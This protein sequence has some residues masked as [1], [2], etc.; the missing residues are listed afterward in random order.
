L[1]PKKYPSDLKAA[2]EVAIEGGWLNGQWRAS[3]FRRLRH[4]DDFNR[5]R[6]GSYFRAG[7]PG[8]IHSLG[9]PLTDSQ[10]EELDA[11]PPRW[12]CVVDSAFDLHGQRTYRQT[13][14]KDP[15]QGAA[16]TLSTGSIRSL[17][18]LPWPVLVVSRE[19]TVWSSQIRTHG[20]T[21]PDHV[22]GAET[23]VIVSAQWTVAL[24]QYCTIALASGDPKPVTVSWLGK[25]ILPF[26]GMTRREMPSYDP[27][28][29]NHV[30]CSYGSWCFLYDCF[31][32]A[33]PF[34]G[35][36]AEQDFESD[37][38]LGDWGQLKIVGGFVGGIQRL[39]TEVRLKLELPS[40]TEATTW[41][42]FFA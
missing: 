29:I 10:L 24:D 40:D 3:F 30:L 26:D 17:E 36:F 9:L 14:M 35:G 8:A 39:T 7:L 11:A 31:L 38:T 19:Q 20:P 1:W 34:C 13:L 23:P 27:A 21:P 18:R 28:L 25:P 32:N 5:E 37:V 2:D 16:L 33:L 12:E 22:L 6:D 15:H 4:Y 41:S 42:K